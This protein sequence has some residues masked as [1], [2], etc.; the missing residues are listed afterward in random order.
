[1]NHFYA[2]IMAG[3][4]GERFW[5]LSTEKRPKQL[6]SLV[7]TRPLVAQSV[8]RLQG[9]IPPEQIFIITNA[10]LVD[11]ACKCVPELPAKNIIGEPIGRDTAA[12]VALGAA[13][14]KKRDPQAAFCVLTA[15]HAIG[16]L[17]LFRNTLRDAL[18]LSLKEDIICTIGI[19]PDHP[20]SG[21]GYIETED[22]CSTGKA[23]TTFMKALRFV[24]KPD[25]TTAATY[26]EAGNF[27]WNSGMFIWS[28]KTIC[29]AFE[30][31][32]PS[33][34]AL[35][36][37]LSPAWDTAHFDSMLA[38]VYAG[39]EKISIDYAVMEKAEN[40]CLAKGTFSWDDVGAWPALEHHFAQD[41]QG[42]T[43]IGCAETIDSKGN[44]VFSKDR[45]TAVIGV[46]DLIV[47][48]AEGATLICPKDKAQDIKKMV[49]Q[50]RAAKTY[51]DLL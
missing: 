35:I 45:L 33:L 1:M 28:V 37:T 36:K 11:E 9:L 12:A 6:L 7:G 22:T 49:Q 29:H 30:Q 38:A 42:N 21:F 14:I 20:S 43:I 27:Y 16:D 23:G 32:C 41:K 15:D 50:L 31:F 26:L 4:K 51:S 13:I 18:E 2:I 44:I 5:P 39:L 46:S 17:D 34:A 48:Q 40:V 3:G 10:D 25:E 19:T 8:E 24:E 47:V